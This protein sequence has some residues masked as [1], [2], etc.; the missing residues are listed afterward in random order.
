MR[1]K[2]P[3]HIFGFAVAH[4]TL[5]IIGLGFLVPRWFNIIVPPDRREDGN[6]VFAPNIT[7][8]IDGGDSGND[9][10]E[11]GRGKLQPEMPD[12]AGNKEISAS[13]DREV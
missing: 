4:C 7:V 10:M 6:K 3:V 5:L 13:D 2:N 1:Y 8:T 9:S 11:A 12:Y